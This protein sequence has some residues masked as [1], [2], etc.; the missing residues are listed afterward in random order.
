M[1]LAVLSGG[2]WARIRGAFVEIL[3]AVCNFDVP[4]ASL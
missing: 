2:F 1:I 3:P 4:L